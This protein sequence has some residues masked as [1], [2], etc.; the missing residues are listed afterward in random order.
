MNQTMNQNNESI[1]LL[2]ELDRVAPF[3]EHEGIDLEIDKTD[4]ATSSAKGSVGST[5]DFNKEGDV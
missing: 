3:N 1:S 2:E 5:A 4:H